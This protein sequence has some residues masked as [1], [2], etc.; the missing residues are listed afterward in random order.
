LVERDYLSS[1][2]TSRVCFPGWEEAFLLSRLFSF[3]STVFFQEDHGPV[4]RSMV[5]ANHWLKSI[6]TDTLTRSALTTLRATWAR[7][8]V[9]VSF[10]FRTS[11]KGHFQFLCLLKTP[12]A[13]LEKDLFHIA[14]RSCANHKL[15][16]R[17]QWNYFSSRFNLLHSGCKR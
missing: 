4:A 5:S 9:T 16:K 10:H 15:R 3:H 2:N 6:K 17:Q 8:L 12:G 13:G 14:E 1:I 7:T 11:L